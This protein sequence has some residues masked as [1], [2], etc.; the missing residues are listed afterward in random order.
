MSTRRALL[1][2]SLCAL[3]LGGLAGPSRAQIA[4]DRV[5]VEL[6]GRAGA[7][8]DVEVRNAG[9]E[10]AYVVVEPVEVVAPGTAEER[11]RETADPAALGLLAAPSRLVLEPGARRIV[12]L[13]R[14]DDPGPHLRVWR[15]G[16][17][18]VTGEATSERSALKVLVGYGVL[19]LGRP[20]E[21]RAAVRA[22][23][24]GDA[25]VL[26][27]DGNADALLFGG[28]HCDAA[29]ERCIELETRRLYPDNRWRVR[30]R[31]DTPV[32]VDVETPSGVRRRRF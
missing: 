27:N 31:W 14:L 22:V 24:T 4:L 12:R 32:V 26:V 5:I 8:A 15:V 11:R 16:I 29:G 9:D 17:R 2:T 3:L 30:L 28:R 25:L 21:P 20:P 10:T 6:P 23:R 7:T 18:P 13:A 1:V 19:V